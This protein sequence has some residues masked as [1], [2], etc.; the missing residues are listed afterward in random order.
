MHIYVAKNHDDVEKHDGFDE[1]RERRIIRERWCWTQGGEGRRKREREWE[2]HPR[3]RE[4]T[5]EERNK[6]ST[7]PLKS[8]ATTTCY[9]RRL[10]RWLSVHRMRGGGGVASWRMES[11][12]VVHGSTDWSHR[13]LETNVEEHTNYFFDRP[14]IFHHGF[15]RSVH[16]NVVH[17]SIISFYLTSR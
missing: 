9:H 2:D 4:T 5:I 10:Y 17:H 6:T 1:E 7:L 8:L 14:S 12:D 15:P 16:L 11:S 13:S 3:W